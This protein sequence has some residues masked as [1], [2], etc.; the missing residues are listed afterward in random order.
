MYVLETVTCTS[1]VRILTVKWVTKQTEKNEPVN[2]IIRT[3]SLHT[4]AIPIS[5]VRVLFHYAFTTLLDF[6]NS[7]NVTDGEVKP[8]YLKRIGKYSRCLSVQLTF[9]SILHLNC[10]SALRSAGNLEGT[11][12]LTDW[13]FRSASGAAHTTSNSGR[14]MGNQAPLPS[15]SPTLKTAKKLLIFLNSPLKLVNWSLKIIRNK[16]TWTGIEMHFFSV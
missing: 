6:S 9:W 13:R 7:Q 3:T 4:K 1:S 11:D 2:Y 14:L 10:V 8:C 15:A 12:W 5:A 16:I